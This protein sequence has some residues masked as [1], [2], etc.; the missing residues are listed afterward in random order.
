MVLASV[1][2]F[3]KAQKACDSRSDF[4]QHR[5]S[6][7]VVVDSANHRWD[8]V[9]RT[10]T[11]FFFPTLRMPTP[12]KWLFWGP[13]HPCVIQVQTLPLEGPWVFWYSWG[14]INRLQSFFFVLGLLWDFY[15]RKESKRFERP[16]R[17]GNV[18]DFVALIFELF[19]YFWSLCL[20]EISLGRVEIWPS[21]CFG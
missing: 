21:V 6:A 7:D 1:R 3:C 4:F 14:R 17:D 19:R 8:L 9:K 16:R 11:G 2:V 20:Q 12:Q 10:E 18:T 5:N 13:T 15:I